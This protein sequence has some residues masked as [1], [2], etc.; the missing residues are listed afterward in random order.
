MLMKRI[1][2]FENAKSIAAK[3]HEYTEENNISYMDAILMYCDTHDVD[4]EYVGEIASKNPSIKA[5][6]Q[7][8]AEELNFLKK[9]TRLPV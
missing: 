8:E 5:K 6:V 1:E 4:I 3:I 9:T 2:K 7:E